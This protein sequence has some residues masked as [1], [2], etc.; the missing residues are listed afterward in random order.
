MGTLGRSSNS[1]QTSFLFLT[2]FRLFFDEEILLFVGRSCKVCVAAALETTLLLPLSPPLVLCPFT[3]RLK[4][5]YR[6]AHF[7]DPALTNAAA[8][9]TI[10]DLCHICFLVLPHTD[11]T[12]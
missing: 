3:F 7:E 8:A 2:S 9:A 1:N 11:W 10:V 6:A 4:F 5:S 12:Y